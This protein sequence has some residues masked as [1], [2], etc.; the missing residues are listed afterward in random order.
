MHLFAALS[1]TSRHVEYTSPVHAAVSVAYV[2]H[3]V[4]GQ[5]VPLA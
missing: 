2:W 5:V 1:Q 4:L 3:E